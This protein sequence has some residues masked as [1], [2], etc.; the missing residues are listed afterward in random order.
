MV[1]NTCDNCKFNY[2]EYYCM[3]PGSDVYKPLIFRDCDHY[4]I[5]EGRFTS[6]EERRMYDEPDGKRDHTRRPR[7][8]ALK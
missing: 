7:C 6:N 3:S 1:P 2:G 5:K 4:E 8:R